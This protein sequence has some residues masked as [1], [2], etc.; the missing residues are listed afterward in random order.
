[1]AEPGSVFDLSPEMTREVTLDVRAEAEIDANQDLP[2][3]RGCEWLLQL[4]RGSKAPPPT[5]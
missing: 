4:G 2:H 5:A 1:M 3:K